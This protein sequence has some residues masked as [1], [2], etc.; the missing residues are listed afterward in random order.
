MINLNRLEAAILMSGL[1]L[2]DIS[3]AIGIHP[4]T[5]LRIRKGLHN[6]SFAVVARLCDILSISMDYLRV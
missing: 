5:F 3:H 6:P 1:S 2:K 4:S